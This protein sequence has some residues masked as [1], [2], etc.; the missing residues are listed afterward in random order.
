LR[1]L[2][3]DALCTLDIESISN[4]N[5]RYRVRY[6][7][8]TLFV[9][10]LYTR[11]VFDFEVLNRYQVQSRIAISGYNDIKGKNFDIVHDI[12]AMSGYKDI[13]V[14]SSISKIWSIFGTICH[15][16]GGWAHR[17]RFRPADGS[18]HLVLDGLY[19]C[20]TVLTPFPAG[21]QQ[22][23]SVAAMQGSDP[24]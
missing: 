4:E 9:L 7:I 18:S 10:K 22:L 19:S 13:D 8:S 5:L 20:V 15:T 16:W 17:P 6:S 11:Y 23:L 1:T 3:K 21:V 12:G 14:F 2:Q 24:A